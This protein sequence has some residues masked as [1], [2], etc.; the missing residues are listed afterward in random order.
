MK[1][2]KTT[3]WKV[4]TIFTAILLVST[5][6]LAFDSSNAVN[7]LWVLNDYV[8]GKKADDVLDE[9]ADYEEEAAADF[10]DDYTA[11]KDQKADQIDRKR[12]RTTNSSIE[13]I[14]EAKEGHMD[15]LDE[16]QIVILKKM[17]QDFYTV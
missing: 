15:D 8:F 9:A 13:N 4:V 2:L 12:E 14:I 16:A 11:R 17:G 1:F 6:G 7:I 5:A 10:E 3:K